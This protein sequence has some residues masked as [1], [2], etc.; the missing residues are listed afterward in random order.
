MEPSGGFG[1]Y[2]YMRR[3]NILK[4]EVIKMERKD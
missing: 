3:K 2:F 1:V 4:I